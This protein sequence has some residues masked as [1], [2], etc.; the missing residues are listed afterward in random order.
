MK[1]TIRWL[2]MSLSIMLFAAACGGEEEDFNLPPK[3]QIVKGSNLY[4]ATALLCFT[5]AVDEQGR[6]RWRRWLRSDPVLAKAELRQARGI[7][8]VAI[9]QP[10]TYTVPRDLCADEAGFPWF[11]VFGI[12]LLFGLVIAVGVYAWQRA[13]RA[14]AYGAGGA[15][16]ARSR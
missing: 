7:G 1:P 4:E 5:N 9:V 13:A 16:G 3:F 8:T 6:G 11:A 10:G 14:M 2:V 15:H 12:S